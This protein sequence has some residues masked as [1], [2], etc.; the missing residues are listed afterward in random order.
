[1]ED[2][3]VTR[4]K[5]RPEVICETELQHRMD[6]EKVFQ[7]LLSQ[8]VTLMLGEVLGLSFELSKWFL[9]VNQ[10]HCFPIEKGEESH[11]VYNNE[12]W[13]EEGELYEY[14]VEWGEVV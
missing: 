5:L 2:N 3:C 8:L 14:G 11:V 9:D 4:L 12:D 1:M 10:S 6:I 7:N 13:F